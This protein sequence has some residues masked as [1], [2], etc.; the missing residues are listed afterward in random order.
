VLQLRPEHDAGTP[1]RILCLGAHS[2]DIEIGCGA[3]LL[4]LAEDMPS[5]KIRWAVFSGDEARRVEANRSADSWLKHIEE[6]SV[7]LHEY[8]DGF[9][10]DQWSEIKAEFERL[11]NS[12]EPDIIF[13]HYRDDLHQDHRVISDLT[14]NTF[15]NHFI[16]E[17]ETPKYDGDMGQPN[18]FIPV[19][20]D[21]AQA[22]VKSLMNY[23]ESQRAKHWFSEELFIG[24]MRIRGMESCS[25]SR[26]AEGF[27]SRKSCLKFK[28]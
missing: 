27:Y 2:D 1:L 24:L 20:S 25:P 19:S 18:F 17:Y 22:K 21:T 7:D 16:L 11:K 13:T 10:P 12:F 28:G 5:C 14:W 23:F 8:R 26:Y 3:S 4:Q 15:R 6:S 9:F